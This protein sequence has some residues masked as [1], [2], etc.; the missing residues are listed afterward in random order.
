MLPLFTPRVEVMR[1]TLYSTLDYTYIS[2][3]GRCPHCQSAL[4][5]VITDS[6]IYTT[7]TSLLYS[8]LIGLKT[9]K[10]WILRATYYTIWLHLRVH[11]K[12]YNHKQWEI[13]AWLDSYE[14]S[15]CMNTNILV[16]S[17]WVHRINM[18]YSRG[19]ALFIYISSIDWDM[20]FQ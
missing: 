9:T 3:V 6:D 12:S 5:A 8:V 19:W 11:P 2:S 1:N 17:L 4:S 13:T 10:Y 15:H 20:L 14:C 18:A 7:D 16:T